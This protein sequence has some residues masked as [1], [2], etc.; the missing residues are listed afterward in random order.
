MKKKDFRE[1]VDQ[2][3]RGCYNREAHTGDGMNGKCP[4]Q[5]FS[6]CLI[7]QRVALPEELNLMM[8]RNSKMQ[9]VKRNGV[10]LKFYD[11]ELW[12]RTDELCL[13]YFGEPVYLRYDPEDL[14]SVRV[15]NEEDRFI[16][17]AALETPLS[18]FA[19]TEEIQAHMQETRKLE[20]TVRAYKKQKGI[21]TEDALVLKLNQAAE[22]LEEEY[23][24]NPKVV[25]LRRF[26][27]NVLAE[28]E[29]EDLVLASGSDTVIDWSKANE[30]LEKIKE[31]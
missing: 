1:Y 26:V 18:Y 25:E 28:Q 24:L 7:E 4:D 5:I 30:R 20:K 8:L 12:F 21:E 23:A 19:S 14:N 15:Y 2:W 11:K 17:E 29:A 10:L 31:E 27:D 6:D 9:K 13:H 3:I 16:G 22:N